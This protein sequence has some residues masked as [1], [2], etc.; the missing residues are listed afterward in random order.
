MVKKTATKKV[1]CPFCE[2]TMYPHLL[3]VHVLNAHPSEIVNFL[4]G[5]TG[6]PEEIESVVEKIG[7]KDVQ[8]LFAAIE[9]MKEEDATRHGERLAKLD[10]LLV[11]MEE[12]KGLTGE[13]E[14][15]ESPESSE[16][17]KEELVG[18]GEEQKE[19]IKE[20]KDDFWGD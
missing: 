5:R 4:E 15:W 8:K 11:K 14:F 10:E 2:K 17:R 3:K 13:K 19:E 20:E 1:K 6:E 16:G 7:S 9:K 12:L 18:G